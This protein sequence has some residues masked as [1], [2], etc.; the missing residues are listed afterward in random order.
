MVDGAVEAVKI[1]CL[2]KTIPINVGRISD[3]RGIDRFLNDRI[4]KEQ[5]RIL[6]GLNLDRQETVSSLLLSLE[7][8]DKI[9]SN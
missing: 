3:I 9:R 1:S 7:V 6:K 4:Y 8:V 5:N 2:E